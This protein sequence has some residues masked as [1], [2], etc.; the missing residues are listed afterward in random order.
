[1]CCVPARW[2]ALAV[3]LQHVALAA[4]W[5][6]LAVLSPRSRRGVVLRGMALGRLLVGVRHDLSTEV[7]IPAHV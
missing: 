1:M 3:L 5:G 2:G 6:A 7:C 4:R